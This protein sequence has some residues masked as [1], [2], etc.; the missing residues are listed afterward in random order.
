MS[1]FAPAL[2]VLRKRLT[3]TKYD[4][5]SFGNSY[6]MTHPEAPAWLKEYGTKLPA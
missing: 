6:A 5:E 1:K 3:E 4:K 2:K